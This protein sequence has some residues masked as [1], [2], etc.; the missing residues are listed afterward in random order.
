MAG[1]VSF[2]HYIPEN[3]ITAN[4]MSRLSGVPSW[5]IK[6]K[7]GWIK[8]HVSKPEEQVTDMAVKASRKALKEASEKLPGFSPESIDAVIYVGSDWK[9]YG[10]WMAATKIQYEIGAI[11]AFAFDI[12]AMC[13]G[14]VLGLAIAKVFINSGMVRNV[15][16]VSASKESYLFNPKDPSTFWL[17]DFADAGAA[18]VVSRE[19]NHN[20]I[21]GSRFYSDGSFYKSVVVEE[22]GTVMAKDSWRNLRRPYFKTLMDKNELKKRLEPKSLESFV[23]VIKGAVEDSGLTLKDVDLV[24][25]NHMKRSFHNRILKAL[26]LPPE[27]GIYLEEY[28]HSQSA[29]QVIGLSIALERK[30]IDKGSI[31]VLASGGTGF[32]WG[33]TVVRWG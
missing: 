20:I 4:E 14:F 22:F 10:V 33:A 5:V 17:S 26:G 6:E 29:D 13:V 28:G 30:L 27:R 19:Y 25:L 8:K 9:D 1:I 12:A 15:L 11:N 24:I 23:K 3:V 16:L 31:I 18:M 21:L 32:L 7:Q 2:A